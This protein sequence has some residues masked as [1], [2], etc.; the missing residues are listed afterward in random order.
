MPLHGARQQ[1]FF[2]MF[3]SPEHDKNIHYLCKYTGE[4]ASQAIRL[5]QAA[6]G[7]ISLA[8]K[9]WTE[10]QGSTNFS[11]DD[12]KSV[13][14]EM[15]EKINIIHTMYAS[16]YGSIVDITTRIGL[17]SQ[18]T[19]PKLPRIVVIG[20][21]SSGKSSILERIVGIALFP[22]NAH[23]GTRMP[24]VL[25][26][27]N[28]DDERERGATIT[29]PHSGGLGKCETQT[30]TEYAITLKHAYGPNVEVNEKN[31]STVIG[32][33]MRELVPVGGGVLE[34][35]L[36]IE[37][38]TKSIPTIEFVDLPGIVAASIEGE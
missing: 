4:E 13:H 10:E 12:T 15:H 3:T 26:L 37:L 35:P 14:I 36:I 19:K 23:T 7:D 18:I 5:L 27:I 22:M 2:T 16:S 17:F 34:E 38:R 11:S 6:Q 29:N 1:N 32:K 8:V 25:R 20:S 21:E 33:L 31:V 9:L 30:N 24:I 28:F